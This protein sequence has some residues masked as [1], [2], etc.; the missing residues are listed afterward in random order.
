MKNTNRLKITGLKFMSGSLKAKYSYNF[1]WM[2][3]PIIQYPQDILAFQEIFWSIKPDLVIETGVAHGGSLV[4]WASMMK[5]ADISGQV[6][7]IEIDLRPQNRAAIHAHPL[8]KYITILEGSSEDLHIYDK[9]SHMASKHKKV[10]VILD[11]SHTEAHVAREL[12]LYS[13]I[14]TS[15]C[16]LIV[17]DTVLEHLPAYTISDRPW[18]KG[19]SPGS[20]VRKF[21]KNHP[22]F[23]P[24]LSI[25]RKLIISTNMGGYL[26]KTG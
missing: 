10:M 5:L 17:C 11:S 9:V 24:D 21:L 18:D 3:R 4:F 13:G 7:G 25:D 2:G 8:N 26:R 14:V 6:V 12:E 1:S 23:E 19:N 20:A 22:E 16:Y 15:G